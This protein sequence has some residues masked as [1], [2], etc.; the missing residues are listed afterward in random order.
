MPEKYG[1]VKLQYFKFPFGF[2]STDIFYDSR[3]LFD[4]LWKEWLYT[5]LLNI[6]GG[7]PMEEMDYKYL[8]SASSCAY[9]PLRWNMQPM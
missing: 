7:T 6:A 5:Q 8:R 4:E 3:S 2:D 1:F 9:A